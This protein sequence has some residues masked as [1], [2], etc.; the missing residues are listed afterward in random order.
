MSTSNDDIWLSSCR[1]QR[2]TKARLKRTCILVWMMTM[3]Q[4]SAS[5]KLAETLAFT[6]SSCPFRE[7]L[8][9]TIP[10]LNSLLLTRS[11]GTALTPI[12]A[13]KQPSYPA[14]RNSALLQHE[15]CFAIKRSCFSTKQ[16]RRLTRIPRE[17]S[18]MRWMWRRRAGPRSLSRTD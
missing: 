6:S 16:P 11:L 9:I 13:A 8:I 17:W 10:P 15:P 1:N 4:M 12:A 14:V 18:R 5:S 3:F 7:S 2:C